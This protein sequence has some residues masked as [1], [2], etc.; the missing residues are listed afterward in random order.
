MIMIEDILKYRMLLEHTALHEDYQSRVQEL[1]QKILQRFQNRQVDRT[2]LESAIKREINWPLGSVSPQEVVKDVAAALRGQLQVASKS[3]QPQSAKKLLA[4]LAE[5][6]AQ[7]LTDELGNIFPDGDPHDATVN[8]FQKIINNRNQLSRLL[9]ADAQNISL[10]DVVDVT[11]SQGFRLQD[12][13][14][15]VLYPG[16]VTAFK[17]HNGHEPWDYLAILW[18]ENYPGQPNPYK[19]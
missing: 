7:A 18:D 13:F 17:K 19:S 5:Y 10:D 4:R 9:G 16:V 11:N 15:N 6:A 2:E 1:A 12:W 8:V 14:W 3:R